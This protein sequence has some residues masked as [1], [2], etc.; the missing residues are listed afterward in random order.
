MKV[1]LAAALVLFFLSSSPALASEPLLVVEEVAITSLADGVG[2][3]CA[4]SLENGAGIVALEIRAGDGSDDPSAVLILDGEAPVEGIRVF[5]SKAL[6]EWQVI[7]MVFPRTSDTETRVHTVGRVYCEGREPALRVFAAALTSDGRRIDIPV[8]FKSL[9]EG[10]GGTQAAFLRLVPNP[11]HGSTQVHFSLEHRG[12]VRLSV[13]D[14]QGRQIRNLL[15]GS[16]GA[17]NHVEQWNGLDDAGRPPASGVYFIK[18]AT[19]DG[20]TVQRLTMVR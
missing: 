10:A 19:I 9:S 18:L 4:V 11:T 3:E 8:F 6:G 7:A 1:C 5:P 2:I 17:G 13:Y 15:S 12:E 16:M 20:T 14:V